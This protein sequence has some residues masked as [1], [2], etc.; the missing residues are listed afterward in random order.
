MDI[1]AFLNATSHTL[2]V[3]IAFISASIV[4]YVVSISTYNLFFH[5]LR[6]FPG[7][8]I[9]AV[10]RIP[11]AYGQMCGT[12]VYSILDLHKRYGPVVRVAPDALSYA[13]EVVYRDAL[14][15]R[16]AGQA[17]FGK[18]GAFAVVPPNGIPSILLANRENHARYRRAF[19]ASFSEKSMQRQQPLIRGYVNS[20]IKGLHERGSEGAQD[21]TQWFNWTSFDVIGALTF[22]ES[23]GCL[24]NQKLH[25]WVKAIFDAA[26]NIAMTA[27]IRQVGLGGLIKYLVPKKAQ[28]GRV[29]HQK[30][31]E[32]KVRARMALGTDQGDFLDSVLEKNG[33]DTGMTFD[34]LASTS[35]L[36]VLA[37]SETT[38]TLLSGVC[39]QLC[40]HPDTLQ[41]AVNEVRSTF[42]SADEIDLY[43]SARL[44][45]L[46]ACLNETMRIYPPVPNQP[47]REAPPGG[48]VID[49]R[50]IPAKTI[51]YVSQ[52]VMN[53]LETLWAKP[54]EFHPERFF[55]NA[56]DVPEEFRNDNHAVFQPFSVGPRNCIGKNLAYAEMRM[57]LTRVLFDFDLELDERSKDWTTA[58]KA[59]KIWEK[60]PLWMKITPRK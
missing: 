50:S 4:L 5:P 22:G 42:E 9:W 54:E 28:Q 57:I 13:D 20:L 33:K 44:S 51:I 45:Y 19:A 11:F 31:S 30:F 2:G 49:G 6:K 24:E 34:E 1:Q 37:G 32:D 29:L 52:Y 40:T 3:A 7:P 16:H 14:A 59:Y 53:H 8:K 58:Q 23:F 56:S 35:S 26:K 17:E 41:K 47:P 43:S 39:Y 55:K 15:H 10:S 36:L 25:P 21:L 18:S 48:G 12:D 27:A 60:P 46:I 38:A